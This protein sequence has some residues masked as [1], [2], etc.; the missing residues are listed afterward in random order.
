MGGFEE[1][2]SGEI[3]KSV[4]VRNRDIPL[5]SDMPCLMQEIRQIEQ[6]REWQRDRMYNITQHITGMPGSG[7]R[8]GGLDESFSLLSEIDAEHEC[9]CREYVSQLRKVQRILYG[10]ESR[11]MRTFVTLKYIKN[12]PDAEIRRELGM[13]R[14]GFD[15]ARHCI[16]SAP[17]MAAVKWQERYVLT[18]DD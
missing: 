17:C 4:K 3:G 10:I 9:K 1:A 2:A 14:R 11:S 7:N 18:D 16:E 8:G 6:R 13:T 15:R 5:L 12:L